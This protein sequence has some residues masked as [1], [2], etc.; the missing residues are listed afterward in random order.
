MLE[1]RAE[2]KPMALQAAMNFLEE[3]P[4]WPELE[5]A[6]PDAADYE[7]LRQIGEAHGFVFTVGELD[8]AFRH[9]CVMRWLGHFPTGIRFG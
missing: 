5:A 3:L 2:G 7:D 8:L 9:R 1:L 4:N 6:L